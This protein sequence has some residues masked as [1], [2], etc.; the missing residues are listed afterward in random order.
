MSL[1]III[2]DITLLRVKK[3]EL[4][5]KLID[6]KSK[7]QYYKKRLIALG[8]YTLPTV[9]EGEEATSLIDY[10]IR[11]VDDVFDSLQELFVENHLIQCALDDIDDVTEFE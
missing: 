11:E 7:I 1:G 8:S 5:D 9:I 10:S 2:K 4:E 6:N 3:S